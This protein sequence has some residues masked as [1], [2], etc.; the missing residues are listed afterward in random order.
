[1]EEKKVKLTLYRMQSIEEFTSCIANPEDKPEIGSSAAAVAAIAASLLERASVH[2][3]ECG[4]NENDKDPEWYSRNT[5]ILR[6]Y[7]TRLVD[8]DV[9]CRAP[10]NRALR[11]DDERRVEASRQAAISICLEIINM[12]GKCLEMTASLVERAD[13][14]T[15]MDLLS[16][17]DLAFAASKAAGRYVLAM[18]RLSPDETYRYVIQRENELT[19]AE[20]K[21]L[22]LRIQNQNKN[23]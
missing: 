8:E 13:D 1:M 10:L 6:S 20:Q 19:M 16:S 11:E 23:N 4:N 15:V 17:A 9:R 21:S 18:S 3:A 2:I 7:M 22:Y 14:E 5:E 12:M